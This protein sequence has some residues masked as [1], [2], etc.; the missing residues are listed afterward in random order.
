M[1]EYRCPDFVAT[2]QNFIEHHKRSRKEGDKLL[3]RLQKMSPA[4]LEQFERDTFDGQTLAEAN[5]EDEAWLAAHPE[6]HVEPT[7][8]ERREWYAEKPTRELLMDRHAVV[9]QILTFALAG[10][11]PATHE[12]LDFSVKRLKLIDEVLLSR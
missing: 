10:N 12:L 9:R 6:E 2:L 11:G 1:M 5:A 8:D 4:E 7:D 3:S